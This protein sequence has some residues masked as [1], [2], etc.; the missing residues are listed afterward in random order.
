MHN[1]EALCDGKGELRFVQR[2]WTP[3][4]QWLIYDVKNSRGEAGKATH[5][6]AEQCI[7]DGR[8]LD[9]SLAL[10]FVEIRR[11]EVRAT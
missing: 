4:I 8:S 1:F 2:Q 3:S 10:Y 9:G 7:P 5:S 6:G 11:P